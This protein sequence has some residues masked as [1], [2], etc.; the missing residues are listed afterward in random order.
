MESGEPCPKYPLPLCSQLRLHGRLRRER[1]VGNTDGS[2]PDPVRSVK[3]GLRADCLLC[4]EWVMVSAAPCHQTTESRDQPCRPTIYHRAITCPR[5]AHSGSFC[6]ASV[7]AVAA[8]DS[9]IPAAESAADSTIPAAESA[10]ALPKW[11]GHA[12]AEA[13]VPS[14]SAAGGW[15]ICSCKQS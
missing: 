15:T 8:A 13:M 9:T 12:R 7:V 1:R 3:S 11:T 10:E 14:A 2:I 6:T 5:A 4:C